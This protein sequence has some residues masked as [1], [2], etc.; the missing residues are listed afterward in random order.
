MTTNDGGP[1]FPR[2]ASIGNDYVTGES[3]VVVDP[4]M[5]MSLRDWFAGMA[6]QGLCSDA[7]MQRDLSNEYGLK[8]E[9]LR[10]FYAKHAY[11]LSDAM[12]KAR[13]Q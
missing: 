6:M 11:M 1:A 8:G 9:A 13:Q 4:Q 7:Q 10:E 3:G 2:P 12:L 5:G